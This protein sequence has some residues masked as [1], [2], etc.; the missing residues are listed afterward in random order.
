MK[1]WHKDCSSKRSLKSYNTNKYNIVNRTK[2]IGSLE[3][4]FII[5]HDGWKRK[6]VRYE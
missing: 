1:K 6:G 2:P 3:E 5:R 4:L